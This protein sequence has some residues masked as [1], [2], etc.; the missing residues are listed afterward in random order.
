MKINLDWGT[1]VV[2]L[3]IT[4][5]LI[6]YTV[7]LWVRRWFPSITKVVVVGLVLLFLSFVAVNQGVKGLIFFGGIILIFIV[8]ESIPN[9]SAPG[10]LGFVVRGVIIVGGMLTLLTLK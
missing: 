10:A 3:L 7:V 4:A 5:P 2:V 6:F 9:E 8:N 1:F